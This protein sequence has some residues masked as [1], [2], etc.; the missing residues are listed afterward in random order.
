MEGFGQSWKGGRGKCR[1]GSVP[2]INFRTPV[3]SWEVNNEF[4]VINPGRT[5]M[6]QPL[7]PNRSLSLL[8]RESLPYQYKSMNNLKSKVQAND[9]K[10]VD[11]YKI[12]HSV[13]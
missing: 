3:F 11:C 7:C 9:F 12:S 10:V 1:S 6:V 2:P 13:R 8:S 4:A 5:A